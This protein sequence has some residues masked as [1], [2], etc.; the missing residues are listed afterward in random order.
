MSVFKLSKDNLA[1][2]EK[3][4]QEYIAK[5]KEEFKG[6]DSNTLGL[7]EELRADKKFNEFIFDEA[8]LKSIITKVPSDFKAK[9]ENTLKPFMKENF[10][11]WLDIF[12]IYAFVCFEENNDNVRILA[13][14][15]NDG[16]LGLNFYNGVINEPNL[17]AYEAL[18]ETLGFLS[19]EELCGLKNIIEND[20]FSDEDFKCFEVMQDFLCA[21][22]IF[23]DF[24]DEENFK[25]VY[26]NNLWIYEMSSFSLLSEDIFKIFN[27][28]SQK[29]LYAKKTFNSKDEVEWLFEDSK[30][31]AGMKYDEQELL[32]FLI[33]KIL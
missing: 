9:L 26:A 8:Y 13:N 18:F 27:A 12:R 5:C 25:I 1:S 2:L 28:T 23:R 24:I 33:N 3:H 10:T 19:T 4:R 32:K 20:Y 31:G 30:Y 17:K 6:F 29:G 21:F 11:Q 16:G 14:S 7:K 15:Y 22:L